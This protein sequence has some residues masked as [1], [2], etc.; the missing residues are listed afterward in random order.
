[1]KRILLIVLLLT[2]LYPQATDAQKTKTDS[3]LLVIEQHDRT[4]LIS[5]ANQLMAFTI[6]RKQVMSL[7]VSTT[8]PHPTLSVCTL[9]TGLPSTT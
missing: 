8:T 3:L 6:R 1:M 5:A 9:G 2:L 7:S 4:R